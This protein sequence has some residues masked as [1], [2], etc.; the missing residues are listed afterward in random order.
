M[1]VESRGYRRC[2]IIIDNL[3]LTGKDE[4]TKIEIRNVIA[5]RIGLSKLTQDRYF[6]ALLKFKFIIK[7][8]NENY[9]IA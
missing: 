4:F 1:L 6:F 2:K 8:E 9:G 7:L 5:K 3:K